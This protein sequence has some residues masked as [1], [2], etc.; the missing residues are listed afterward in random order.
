MHKYITITIALGNINNNYSNR[1]YGD[2]MEARISSNKILRNV[3]LKENEIIICLKI[4][5]T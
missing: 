5:V 3:L 1:Y 4:Q 2:R